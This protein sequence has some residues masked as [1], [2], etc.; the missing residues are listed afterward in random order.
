MPSK[1]SF[2][3]SGPCHVTEDISDLFFIG[4]NADLLQLALD[5][6]RLPI[7]ASIAGKKADYVGVKRASPIYGRGA[8]TWQIL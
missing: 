8:T 7:A 5:I 3:L 1:H 6:D 4:A 2:D